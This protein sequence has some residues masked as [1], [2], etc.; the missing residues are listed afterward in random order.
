MAADG[1]PDDFDAAF[2]VPALLRWMVAARAAMAAGSPGV[3]VGACERCRAP[4]LLSSR[5][6]V[7]LPC[8]H[9]A[10]P[11]TGGAAE[12][13]VDQWTEPWA[14]VEGS[15]A[16]L[17]YRLAVVDDRGGATA[18]CAACGLP[19]AARDPS[20]RCGR[21]GAATWVTR[22]ERGGATRRV[23]LGVRIDGARAGRPVHRLVSVA[24]GEVTLRRDGAL[25]TAA[26]SGRSLLGLTGI[27]CAIAIG[28]AVLMAFAVTIAI[29]FATRR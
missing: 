26:E 5:E 9:C 2:T 13:L 1:Q 7:A 17:E 19:T 18:G 21:C 22:V 28:L 23:Q 6:P 25:G 14:R 12:T 3:A 20:M 27:G 4:L 29:Y 10:E 16:S 15:G 24:E 8:P 11:V